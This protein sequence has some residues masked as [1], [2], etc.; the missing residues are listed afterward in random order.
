MMNIFKIEI[1]SKDNSL[2]IV[3]SCGLGDQS[4]P[5]REAGHARF[6]YVQK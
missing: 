4:R 3:F 1:I 2:R 6:N 5:Q